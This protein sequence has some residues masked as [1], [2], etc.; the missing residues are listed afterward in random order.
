[1]T[2]LGLCHDHS[3]RNPILEWSECKHYS[4]DVHFYHVDPK[5]LKNSFQKLLSITLQYNTKIYI[6]PILF[7]FMSWVG[8][9]GAY[10]RALACPG[11]PYG[12]TL[13]HIFRYQS[14]TH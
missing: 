1:M 7:I 6:I 13:F 14:V 8:T 10:P 3:T 2:W 5:L 9:W 4:N 11:A 12:P